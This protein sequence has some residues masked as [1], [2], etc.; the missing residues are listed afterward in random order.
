MFG[1]NDVD[2][3]FLDCGMGFEPCSY[4]FSIEGPIVFGICG[5]VDSDES[6]AGFDVVFEGFFLGFFEDV[7][8]GAEEDDGFVG[9]EVFG[10]EGIG[11]FG[12]GCGE[13]VFFAELL[14]GFDAGLDGI[15]SVSG[16]FGEDE[17][18]GLRLE[19]G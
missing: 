16:G 5:G 4:E 6:A 19:K 2:G 11:V 12:G 13:V 8:C 14:D 9:F 10:G 15:V 18:C 7:A 17:D 3:G 1:I